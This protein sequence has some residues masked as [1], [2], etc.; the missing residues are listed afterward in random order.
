[1]KLDPNLRHLG[2]HRLFVGEGEGEG[3]EGG[4][5]GS[6]H[7]SISETTKASPTY[8]KFKAAESIASYAD[9]VTSAHSN[10][11]I[12]LSKKGIPVPDEK[13]GPVGVREFFGKLG[14]PEDA[15]KYTR[16]VEGL[17][18]GANVDPD[19]ENAMAEACWGIGV[20]DPQ[21]QKL[22]GAIV[23][24]QH[25]QGQ[26]ME[27]DYKEFLETAEKEMK[28]EWG[29]AY[30]ARV[31]QSD[32]ALSLVFGDD[33]EAVG[34]IML[35][36]KPFGSHPIFLRAFGKLGAMLEEADLLKGGTPKIGA[37]TPDS[38][39]AEWSRL[40]GDSSFQ[41]ALMEKD[42]VGHKEAVET[43]TRL[44]KAMHPG[45]AE[46]GKGAATY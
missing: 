10:A 27:A 13:S 25:E 12:A 1:M 3:G 16:G 43:R 5:G 7:D 9:Q 8:E 40:Q 32:Q 14:C 46:D 11:E 2:P 17:P 38:A 28:T 44:Y 37:L 36:G 29:N 35:D 39:K 21:W 31:V 41:E 42:H 26:K 45:G 6:W 33:A 19:F 23:G 30:E 22:R 4:G 20:A 34:Q 15:T 18:E 24:Y